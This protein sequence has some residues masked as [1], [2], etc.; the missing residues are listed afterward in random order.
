MLAAVLG[1]SLFAGVAGAATENV[2]LK[3]RSVLS[4]EESTASYAAN[5]E[6][7]ALHLR[8][9]D[10]E[11]TIADG[12]GSNAF[13]IENAKELAPSIS[14]D[15]LMDCESATAIQVDGAPRCLDAVK[16]RSAGIDV[17]SAL[18]QTVSV[19]IESLT[20]AGLAT[21]VPMAESSNVNGQAAQADL[22]GLLVPNISE[23]TARCDAATPT[24]SEVTVPVPD[25]LKP[26]I[27]GHL[28]FARC[29]A[30]DE[31][32]TSVLHET[33]EAV[34]DVTLNETLVDNVP[35]LNDTVDSLQ[36]TITPLPEAVRNPVDNALENVQTR[37]NAQ[38]VVKVRVAPTSGEL[39][40]Q[41]AGVA[42]TAVSRGVTIDV[43]PLQDLPIG[44]M[45]GIAQITVGEAKASAAV[46]DGKPVAAN[47]VAVVR[48][49]VLNLTVPDADD[50]LLDFTLPLVATDTTILEDT[51]LQS[52]IKVANAPTPVE[53]C[54]S[55]AGGA[56]DCVANAQAQSLTISIFDPVLA[57]GTANPLPNVTL[58]L[59]SA[60]ANAQE[61]FRPIPVSNPLPATELPRTGPLPL[62]TMLGGAIM[63]LGALA[64]RRRFWM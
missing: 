18:D 22:T 26:V 35:L 5:T 34:L 4:T 20:A 64:A 57:N 30:S 49:K 45:D 17:G 8:L 29:S 60:G 58:Q 7:V 53:E 56:R 55:A 28:A 62:A 25:P 42:S 38:P 9:L 44:Q 61:Q 36:E 39:T 14:G 23:A 6:T 11:L 33:G 12:A 47:D 15:L 16:L 37:L 32:F 31:G 46:V 21:M 27:D 54:K 2:V 10:Q 59:A 51:P 50:V 19:G 13:A 52:T 63:A 3:D 1:L 40:G 48:V 24:A 43:L 41:V